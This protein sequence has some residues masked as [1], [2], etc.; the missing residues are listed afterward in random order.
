LQGLAVHLIPTKHCLITV[1]GDASWQLEIKADDW[2]PFN[3]YHEVIL[4]SLRLSLDYAS[5]LLNVIAP[6]IVLLFLSE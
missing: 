3:A 4:G 5:N 6:M 1:E 2:F